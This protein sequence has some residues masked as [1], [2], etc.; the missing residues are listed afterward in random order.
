MSQHPVF[1]SIGG[2]RHQ[3][4]IA[5]RD[6]DDADFTILL[7]SLVIGGAPVARPAAS[8]GGAIFPP[9]GRSKG[10]PVA[11]AT[12]GDL[13]YYAAGCRRSLDDPS[14]ERWHDKERALLAAIEAEI[15]RQGGGGG[16]EAPRGGGSSSMNDDSDIPFLRPCS[17]GDRQ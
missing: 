6:G 3:I 12:R 7:G 1:V 15:A 10:A 9:Y 4:G 16:D 14:K 2:T 8:G 13:D 5:T 17:L 11:G